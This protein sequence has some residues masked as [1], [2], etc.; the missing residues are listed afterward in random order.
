MALVEY[1]LQLVADM[2]DWLYGSVFAPVLDALLDHPWLA[3]VVLAVV[4]V[5]VVVDTLRTEAGERVDEDALT[6]AEWAGRR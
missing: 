4:L 1:L 2:A 3:G 6:E 5:V